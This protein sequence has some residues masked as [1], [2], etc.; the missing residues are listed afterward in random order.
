MWK[1]DSTCRSLQE[2]RL[3]DEAVLFPK[4]VEEKDPL[5]IYVNHMKEFL[6]HEAQVFAMFASLQVGSMT[7]MADL[8]VVCKFIEVFPYDIIDLPLEREVEFAIDL[9]PDTRHV[10]MTPYIVS[11]VELGELKK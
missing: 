1:V 5:F 4:L 3:L 9:V 8:L 11:L 10:S 6:K 2:C 7:S